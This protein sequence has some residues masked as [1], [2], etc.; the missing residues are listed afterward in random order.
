MDPA[1]IPGDKVIVS[2]LIPCPRIIRNF[3]SLHKGE[4]PDITRLKGTRAVRS[5]DV[6]IFNFPYSDCNR[7]EMNMNVFYAK[8]CVAIPGDTL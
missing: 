8:R 1:I 7:L 5:N 6:L 4:K 3:F 2:K